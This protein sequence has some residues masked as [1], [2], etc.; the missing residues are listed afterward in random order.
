MIETILILWFTLLACS[1]ALIVSL[2]GHEV[3]Q[4]IRKLKQGGT[5]W[6]TN[7]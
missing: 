1:V 3:R 6:D 7:E 2:L 5:G 4:K